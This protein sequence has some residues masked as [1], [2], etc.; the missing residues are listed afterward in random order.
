MR[1]PIFTAV[2]LCCLL[3][4][5][6]CHAATANAPSQAAAPSSASAQHEPVA[7]PAAQPADTQAQ[8]PADQSKLAQQPPQP[9]T[10]QPGQAPAG[11]QNQPSQPPPRPAPSQS[12]QPAQATKPTSQKPSRQ[13]GKKT[14]SQAGQGQENKQKSV[15]EIKPAPNGWTIHAVDADAHELLTTFAQRAGLPLVVDDTVKRHITVHIE[16]HPARDILALIVDAYGFSFAEVNGVYIVSE[17]M[18]KSPSSYLL[19][20]IASVTLKYVSPQQAHRLLPVFLQG[21]VRINTD[22]NAVVL[23]GPQPLLEKFRQHIQQF[24]VPAA[25]VMLD[26][27]VVEFTDV[28]ADTLA[29]QLG[30]QNANAG[31]I[32]D[33]LTGQLTL[34]AVA[35]LPQD[36]YVRLQALVEKK[37]ARV[38]AN[39]RIA[40]VSGSWA[41]IFIGQQQYVS[42]PI[43][44]ERRGQANYIDAGVRLRIFPLTGGEGEIILDLDEEI[45]TLSP[46]DPITGLP[47]K[48][49][50]TANTTVRIRD[51]QT[52]I[53]GGL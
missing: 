2:I 8:Q 38:R 34:L 46:P 30:W 13:Q 3:A 25:Q 12:T 21:Q 50:R 47:N 17:G 27:L 23:S 49:I 40:T 18:P 45:S 24:D 42:I 51:G 36:F 26:V 11:N 10:P 14:E 5:A 15:I 52:V 9:G 53:I 39:P 31:I 7:T 29:A 41:E 48:T 35:E 16:N 43:S 4:A 32:T 1:Q 20:D 33:S 28:T 6:R 19:S 37:K 22:Q 44:T